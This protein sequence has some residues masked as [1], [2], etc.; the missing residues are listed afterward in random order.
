MAAAPPRPCERA[1]EP[2]ESAVALDP[3]RAVS[4]ARLVRIPA[5][6]FLF[7]TDPA[8]AREV[9]GQDFHRDRAVQARAVRDLAHHARC[10]PR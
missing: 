2:F 10:A 4:W 1:R 6:S 7:T 5:L 9:R 3:G 8:V